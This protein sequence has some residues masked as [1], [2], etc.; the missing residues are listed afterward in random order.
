MQRAV[1]RLSVS[2][3]RGEGT[4]ESYNGLGQK[5]AQYRFFYILSERYLRNIERD[6][7]KY[8]AGKI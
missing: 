7:C 2:G 5:M 4:D 3:Y 6:Y 1:L 8:S